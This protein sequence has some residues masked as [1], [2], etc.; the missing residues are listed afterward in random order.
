MI[1][2]FSNKLKTIFVDSSLVTIEGKLEQSTAS[3]WSNEAYLQPNI[4]ISEGYPR[5]PDSSEG[6][7]PRAI[8]CYMGIDPY[9]LFF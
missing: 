6:L 4:S 9:V 8:I 5:T 3:Y 7:I 1:A 2:I